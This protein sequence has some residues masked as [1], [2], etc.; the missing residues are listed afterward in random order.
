MQSIRTKGGV[1]GRV[2]LLRGGVRQTITTQQGV[3]GGC[4][5]KYYQ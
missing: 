3:G 5:S 4:N 2:L 1:G